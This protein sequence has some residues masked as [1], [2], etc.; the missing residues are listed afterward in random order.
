MGGGVICGSDGSLVLG[1]T[2]A[3]PWA[4]NNQMKLISLFEGL[5][6]IEENSLMPIE[7]CIDSTEVLSWLAN[8][9]LFY[10]LIIDECKSKLR[11]LERPMVS[12]CYREQNKVADVLANLGSQLE[13]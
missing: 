13:L 6:P 9:N 2:K 10:D 3:Y 8:E 7:I 11:R 4:S 12:H 5:R 1:F